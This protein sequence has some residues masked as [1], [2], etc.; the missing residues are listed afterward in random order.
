MVGI[1]SDKNFGLLCS[2]DAVRGP[3]NLHSPPDI[4]CLIGLV[5]GMRRMKG[6]VVRGMPV[7]GCYDKKAP[8]LEKS[9]DGTYTLDVCGIRIRNG[10]SALTMGREIPLDVGN[11]NG[12]FSHGPSGKPDTIIRHSMVAK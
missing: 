4:L 3:E 11:N 8:S 9:R 5:A 12:G 7:L 6:D 10:E 2:L 1:V